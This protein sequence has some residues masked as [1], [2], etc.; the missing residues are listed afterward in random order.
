MGRATPRLV[1]SGS[2]TKNAVPWPVA[3][4]HNCNAE[5]QGFYAMGLT[6]TI[7]LPSL[8]GK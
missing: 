3:G 5:F 2:S 4:Y 8:R 6:V 1:H 7:I